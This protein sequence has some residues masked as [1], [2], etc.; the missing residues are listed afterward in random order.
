MIISFSSIQVRS[1]VSPRQPGSLQLDASVHLSISCQ[2][3][4]RT[5]IIYILQHTRES[6]SIKI[7]IAQFLPRLPIFVSTGLAVEK[8]RLGI[9]VLPRPLVVDADI[10]P[11][12]QSLDERLRLPSPA[13]FRLVFLFGGCFLLLRGRCGVVAL[14][15]LSR[16]RT[17]CRSTRP[18]RREVCEE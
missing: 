17:R 12:T 8:V 18:R 7:F 6:P 13:F 4:S 10:D 2:Q 3:V 9:L 14:V 5:F 11:V 1:L 16:L 15:V